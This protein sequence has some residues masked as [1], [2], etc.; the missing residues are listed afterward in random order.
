MITV[1]V[2][3]TFLLGLMILPKLKETAMRFNIQPH[4]IFVSSEVHGFAKFAERKNPEFLKS[5]GNEKQA[6]MADR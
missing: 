3:S 1:N 2:V 4:L 6:N 5:I